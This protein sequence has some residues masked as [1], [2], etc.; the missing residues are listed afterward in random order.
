LLQ[1]QWVHR[2]CGLSKLHHCSQIRHLAAAGPELFHLNTDVSYADSEGP[3]CLESAPA[4][5][6]T[7]I[8]TVAACL[9]Y[10]PSGWHGGCPRSCTR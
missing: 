2:C 5:L 7:L 3:R 9:L 10:D 4:A 8:F 6:H 1:L